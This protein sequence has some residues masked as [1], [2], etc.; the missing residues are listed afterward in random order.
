MFPQEVVVA[1]SSSSS[2]GSKRHQQQQQWAMNADPTL[3]LRP[4]F[5]PDE[6]DGGSPLKVLPRP[7]V[8]AVLPA[9]RRQDFHQF[10]QRPQQQQRTHLYQ[11]LPIKS[12]VYER[13]RDQSIGQPPTIVPVGVGLKPKQPQQQQ[14]YHPSPAITS[15][16]PNS[17]YS[18]T[19]ATTTDVSRA[20]DK[21]IDRIDSE[22]KTTGKKVNRRRPF[23][24]NPFNFIIQQGH[25][26]VRKY[27]T[28]GSLV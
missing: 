7:P 11:R 22:A 1:L 10:S 23:S 19:A 16:K 24:F 12:A 27:G 21:G 20:V 18:S 15:K 13:P 25:S 9:G 17:I 4:L 26:R 28:G 2:N 5:R 3:K 8:A 14:H 6:K